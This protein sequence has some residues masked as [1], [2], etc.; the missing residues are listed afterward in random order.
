MIRIKENCNFLAFSRTEL[1]TSPFRTVQIINK[2]FLAWYFLRSLIFHWRLLVWQYYLGFCHVSAWIRHRYAHIPSLLNPPS[3]SH[4]IAPL[5]VGTEHLIWAPHVIRQIP[6]GWL[7]YT[8]WW[9]CFH[10]TLWTRP[11]LSP[12]LWCWRRLLRL[13]WTT[14]RSNIH[15]IQ[16]P[17]EGLMLKLKLQYFGHLMWRD[18]S[19]WKDPDAGKDWGQEEKGMTED[20]M[21]G[22][23]HWLNGHEFE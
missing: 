4:P 13:P 15:W 20:Q 11:T 23:H 10:A 6:T 7:F 5:Q 16:Y 3:V 14:R 18:D 17:L 12:T 8:W 19:I 22:W 1:W 2:L 21:V 9:I